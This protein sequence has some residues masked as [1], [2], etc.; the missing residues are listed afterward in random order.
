MSTGHFAQL[1]SNP[2]LDRL[3]TSALALLENPGMKIESPGLLQALHQRGAT[4]DF[5]KEIVRF[6]AKLVEETIDLTVRQERD[7]LAEAKGNLLQATKCLAFSWHT[8]F[9]DGTPEVTFSFGGGCP[10]FYDYPAEKVRESTAKN[11]LDMIH[12]AEGLP[13]VVTVGNPVHPVVDFDGKKTPPKM[14]AIKG[15]ALV[16]KNSS[17]PGSTAL[18]DAAQ[19]DY[20]V[21]IGT[22]IRGSF[23]NYQMQPLFININDTVPP[24]K[25]SR[26]E[27]A[28]I[29]A[30][31]KKNLPVFILPMPM[32][33][34]S[35]PVFPLANAII[36]AAEI[37]GVWTAVKA[38][39]PENPVECSI[40]SGVLEPITGAASFS[41]PE[42][43]MQ[44]VMVAQLFRKR[45]HL[46]CGIGAGFIDAAIPGIAATY[47]RTLKCG[48]AA[49]CGE[50]SFPVGILAAGN[51]YSP[52]QAMIDMD[53]ARSQQRFYRDIRPNFDEAL[54]LIRE[55]GIEG[56]FFDT[57][58][59][60]EHFREELWI[61]QVFSRSKSK[62]PRDAKAADPVRRA[63]EKW[64][65]ILAKTTPFELAP[66]KAREI[67]H[68]VKKAEQLLA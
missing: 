54:A 44:D 40:V 62:E 18:M 66:E 8:A 11:F 7:R 47:E 23:Q 35:G 1:L 17:K 12:L 2:E 36:G 59:T 63:Y 53:I 56:M 28:I 14:M 37:L 34:I 39:N 43:A 32:M 30:L 9:P 55:Q 15:A 21:E 48:L 33:G 67:D 58:H 61:P 51:I 38:L 68:I 42:T 5:E 57:D 22:V 46:R 10:L 65:Q 24:L 6:P 41:A 16:A 3:H 26:P 31:I 13:E 49:S 4:V 25:L 60:A 20:L 52:E 19:L 27:G 64:T 50:F 45:Y 29:E